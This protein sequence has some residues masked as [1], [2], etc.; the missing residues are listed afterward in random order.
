MNNYLENTFFA[1]K[2]M[3]KYMCYQ[4]RIQSN[5]TLTNFSTKYFMMCKVYTDV[6][7]CKHVCPPVRKTIHSLKLVDYLHAQADKP[8]YNYYLFFRNVREW[9]A[10]EKLKRL[11]FAPNVWM[12]VHCRH[13][14][15]PSHGI[16][17]FVV[18]RKLL[19]NHLL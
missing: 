16:M 6:G 15:R 11:S 3:L 17:T 9:Y 13:V 5:A 7:T 19:P 12:T 14:S 1:I 8:W 18:L 4:N 2:A 10:I